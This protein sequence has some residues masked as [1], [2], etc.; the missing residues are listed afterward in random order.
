MLHLVF[1][2]AVSLVAYERFIS[3]EDPV[4]REKHLAEHVVSMRNHVQQLSAKNYQALYQLNSLDFVLMFIPIE[5]AFSI[6]FQATP[7]TFTEAFSRNVLITAPNTLLVTLRTIAFTWKQEYQSRNA[8]EIAKQAATLYDKFVLFAGSVQT[9]GQRIDQ[10]QEAYEQAYKQLASGKG[11]LIK[12]AEKLRDLGV[13]PSKSMPQPLLDAATMSEEKV[14]LPI[15]PLSES[16]R[17][18][19]LGGEP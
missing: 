18:R 3:E 13:Q 7:D 6:A 4:L 17:E 12:Q 5:A 1:E 9:I 16:G 15:V 19:L 10:S 8:Q 14:E 2:R 11:N